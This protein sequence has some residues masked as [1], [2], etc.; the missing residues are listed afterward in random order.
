MPILLVR[1]HFFLP[2]NLGD[3]QPSREGRVPHVRIARYLSWVREPEPRSL[4]ARLAASAYVEL[5]EDRR[6]VMID[7]LGG[8]EQQVGNVGAAQ[9]LR[10]QREHLDLA[11][12]QARRIVL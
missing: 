11:G 7:R 9:A 5:P 6:D 12:G 2:A 1:R 10:D 4:G 8:K 3:A